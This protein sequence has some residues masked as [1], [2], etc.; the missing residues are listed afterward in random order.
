[1]YEQPGLKGVLACQQSLHCGLPFRPRRART[2]GTLPR[3]WRTSSGPN[4]TL[5]NTHAWATC[6]SRRSW[7]ETTWKRETR[8][9]IGGIWAVPK[10]VLT[11]VWNWF[12]GLLWIGCLYVPHS[13]WPVATA[14]FEAGLFDA[15]WVSLLRLPT[16]L[17]WIYIFIFVWKPK[18]MHTARM[19]M[20]HSSI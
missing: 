5:P 7:R 16:V 2:S 15:C 6:P 19:R 13:V 14:A 8:A 10:L 1:M 4:A 9:Q 20:S 3:C 11:C 12:P 17:W 18:C